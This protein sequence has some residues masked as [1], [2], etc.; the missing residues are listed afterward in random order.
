[1]VIILTIIMTLIIM[2]ILFIILYV[3]DRNS[4]NNGICKKCGHKLKS[5]DVDSGGNVGYICENCN[6]SIWIGWYKK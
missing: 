2:L 6:Y 4:Y 5:F 1:M 3:I